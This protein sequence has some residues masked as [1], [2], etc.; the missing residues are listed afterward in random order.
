MD[1]D[2]SLDAKARKHITHN[3]KARGIVV[4]GADTADNDAAQPAMPGYVHHK[5]NVASN[6]DVSESWLVDTGCPNDL[7]S[8]EQVS[9][10]QVCVYA[11]K[12]V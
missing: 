5:Y 12:T 8:E 10:H 3:N 4:S 1:P 2:V 6:V 9:Q 7:A 11:A